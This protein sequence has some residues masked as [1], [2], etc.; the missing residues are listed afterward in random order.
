MAEIKANDKVRVNNKERE[1]ELTNMVNEILLSVAKKDFIPI[2]SGM[3]GTVLKTN[4]DLKTALVDFDGS[5]IMVGWSVLEVIN[6]S[7]K[8]VDGIELHLTFYEDGCDV[9]TDLELTEYQTELL[10]PLLE[11]IGIVLGVNSND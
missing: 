2:E 9:N 11:A 6:D 1:I 8:E 3:E 7:E 10:A 5:E 4:D